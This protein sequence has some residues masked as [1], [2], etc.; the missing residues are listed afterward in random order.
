[1]SN[2]DWQM[3]KNTGPGIIN[4]AVGEPI[5]LQNC[6]YDNTPFLDRLNTSLNLSDTTYPP[7]G[8]QADLINLIKKNVA[9]NYEHIII[10]N[11]AKQGILAAFYAAKEVMKINSVS[12]K[13][14]YWPSYPTLAKQIG[15]NFNTQ[16]G[17]DMCAHCITTP[18][19]PDGTQ[20]FDP[21]MTYYLWDAAYAHEVYGYK[22]ISPKHQVAVFSC[23]K[24]LGVSGLRIGFVATNNDELAQAMAY[25]VEIS[26]SGVSIASQLMLSK[27]L[28]AH[29]FLK[30]D[31]SE[32]YGNARQ[33]LLNNV[34]TFDRFVR[35]YCNKVSDLR[36]GMFAW[37]QPTDLQRFSLAIAAAK[38]KLVTGEACGGLPD[39]FRMSLGLPANDFSSALF[40][41]NH[42]YTSV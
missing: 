4:L 16:D 27:L 36:S 6:L 5:F 21:G 1:M 9:P 25:Y 28:E 2:H 41:F 37:F 39:H 18:N 23:A 26:T 13:A 30:R 34:N 12:H 20:D 3:A 40:A 15:L 19:N 14:P 31:S 8:G 11:G 29:E 33:C 38:I 7:F 42:S 10:T 32:L 35:P 17:R 22:G 24:M